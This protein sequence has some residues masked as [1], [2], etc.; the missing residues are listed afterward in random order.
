MNFKSYIVFLYYCYVYNKL[1]NYFLDPIGKRLIKI[2]NKKQ[3]ICNFAA[4]LS[5]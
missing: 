4:F 5:F 2:R 3:N 1:F